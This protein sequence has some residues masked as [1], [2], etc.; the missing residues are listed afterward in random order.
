MCNR[1]SKGR[2]TDRAKDRDRDFN[3]NWDRDLGKSIVTGIRKRFRTGIGE[4]IIQ[5]RNGKRI[6]TGNV[7]DQ[8]AGCG[9]VYL[10]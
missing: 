1:T 9:A 7:M 8:N 4:K 5:T 10:N 2:K 3:R 6:V